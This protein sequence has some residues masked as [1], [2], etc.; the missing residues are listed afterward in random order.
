MLT[1]GLWINGQQSLFLSAWSV[2]KLTRHKLQWQSHIRLVLLKG[3]D[4]FLFMFTVV[5][6]TKARDCIWGDWWTVTHKFI[7]SVCAGGRCNHTVMKGKFC[8]FNEILFLATCAMQIIHYT[9]LPAQWTHCDG[10]RLPFTSQHSWY[11]ITPWWMLDRLLEIIAQKCLL[12]LV[13]YCLM[14]RHSCILSV[15]K[16]P[17]TLWGHRILI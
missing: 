8:F 1:V 17:N 3:T 12:C 15:T 4:M 10:W 11:I 2:G 13:W 16:C 14:Q 9:I 5:P 6:K 7:H